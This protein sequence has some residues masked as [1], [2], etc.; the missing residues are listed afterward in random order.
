MG[1]RYGYQ[2]YQL[3]LRNMQLLLLWHWGIGK[4]CLCV[5]MWQP[6]QRLTEFGGRLRQDDRA[7][8]GW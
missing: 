6:A 8:A 5:Q 2:P 1:T 7:Q 4:S 3:H